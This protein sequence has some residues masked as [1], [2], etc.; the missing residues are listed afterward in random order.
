MEYKYITTPLLYIIDE[1]LKIT[2]YQYQNL[3][4]NNQQV[5]T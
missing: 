2:N 4:K 5:L 3:A 1:K